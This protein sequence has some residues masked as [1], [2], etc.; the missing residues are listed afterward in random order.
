MAC[1]RA[2]VSGPR[3]SG[4]RD[5]VWLTVPEGEPL[6]GVADPGDVGDIMQ[7]ADGAGDGGSIVH[8]GVR[9]DC[10]NGAGGGS[11][12]IVGGTE[13]GG[14]SVATGSR[15]VKCVGRSSYTGVEAGCGLG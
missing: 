4:A 9:S 14:S 15:I 3:S 13:E 5:K 6:W 8:L 7:S 12:D 11:M 10:G 1:A 2:G